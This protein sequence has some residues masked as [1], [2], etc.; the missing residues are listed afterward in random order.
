MD[1]TNYLSLSFLL[2]IVSVNFCI[3]SVVNFVAVEGA[4]SQRKRVTDV[5]AWARK[6]IRRMP[7]TALSAQARI[8]LMP[9]Y[10]FI[11]EKSFST[12]SLNWYLDRAS[13]G[14]MSRSDIRQKN[15]SLPVISSWTVES[16]G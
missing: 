7:F 12:T 5:T 11:D 13:R 2:T 9:M 8:S 10:D 1:S 6:P 15:L 16:Q 3:A 4:G 14:S